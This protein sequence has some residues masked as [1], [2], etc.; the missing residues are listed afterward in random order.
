M[1]NDP[2]PHGCPPFVL[3]QK[4]EQYLHHHQ[5]RHTAVVQ[6]PPYRHPCH[7]GRDAPSACPPA[8]LQHG[9]SMACL[10]GTITSHVLPL[11]LADDAAEHC[12]GEASVSIEPTQVH[13][14]RP[15]LQQ[16]QLPDRQQHIHQHIRQR[17]AYFSP[18]SR[19]LRYPGTSTAIN[20]PLWADH[21][22]PPTTPPHTQP[23]SSTLYCACLLEDLDHHLRV[24]LS[25]HA[26]GV[27]SHAGAL[28]STITKNDKCS[29][30][31]GRPA[32][33]RVMLKRP[34]GTEPV[35]VEAVITGLGGSMYS[36][37]ELW[38]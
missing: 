27:G 33:L 29:A 38:L 34:L 25:R 15:H 5:G 9:T 19:Q 24:R 36:L 35:A 26:I 14:H 18:C 3:F 6:R 2:P 17:T 20:Q 10:P 22:T 21:T 12:S 37:G 13:D 8:T 28:G 11:G 7:G 31:T 32:C 23:P 16:R 30:P 4:K 1:L